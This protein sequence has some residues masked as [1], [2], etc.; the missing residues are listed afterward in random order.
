MHI[1]P[2]SGAPSDTLPSH[3][4]S[5]LAATPYLI[6]NGR[7]DEAIAHYQHALGTTTTSLQRFG[8]NNPNCPEALRNNVMH[9]ELKA[10]HGTLMLS[11][12]PGAA[13]PPPAG[14]VNVAL[15][16]NDEAQARRS[17][18]ILADAGTVFQPLMDA[19]WGALFG[20]VID[21]YGVSWMFNC[22]KQPA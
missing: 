20:A 13:P 16:M 7:A 3:P 8:D 19:P 4:M 21:R 12:G 18:E 1:R 15:H 2:L 10:G 6:L 5:I 14:A 17:F 11:D 22:E 9:A